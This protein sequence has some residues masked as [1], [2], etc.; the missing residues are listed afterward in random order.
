MLEPN[1]VADL[2]FSE[3]ARV[4]LDGHAPHISAGTLR[5]YHN[6]IAALTPFFGTFTL[7]QIHI[8]H[9]EQYQKMRSSGSE[10]LRAAG[11]SRVNHELNTLSQILAR[12]GLWAPLA[13]SYKPLRLPRP[14][15]GRSLSP[16]ESHRLFSMAASNPRWK[17]AYCCA[18]ISVNTTSGPNEIRHLRLRDIDMTIPAIRITEGVKNEYRERTIPLN[19]PASWAIGSLLDRARAIGAIEPEHYLLPHRA[20]NGKKGFD[21][22]RPITSWRGA[23]E[24]FTNA[25]NLCG[26][27]FYD[28][29]HDA[30]TSLLADPDTSERTVMEIAGHVTQAM[31]SRYSHQRMITKAQAVD[32]L[33][34]KSA[35]SVGRAQLILM[36]R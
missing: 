27:R 6:C 4:W 1:V 30:I 2:G 29:R 8:G 25:A 18:L 5:D 35:Q 9:F 10:E 33:A 15:V 19:G 22:T 32:R 31:L 7:R 28:L 26:L 16:E 11:P 3:A 34:A 20:A 13:P 24:Q 21:V 12:A 17:V 23:W 14:K 36:K